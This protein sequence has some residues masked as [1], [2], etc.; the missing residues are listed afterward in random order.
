[1]ETI[2]VTYCVPV[3]ETPDR[4]SHLTG[5]E[6]HQKEEKLQK[7]KFKKKNNMITV[8]IYRCGFWCWLVILRTFFKVALKYWNKWKVS[9]CPQEALRF[10][11]GPITSKEAHQHHDSTHGYQDVN[12]CKDTDAQCVSSPAPLGGSAAP[13][14]GICPRCSWSA[15][16]GN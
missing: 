7:T 15:D 10:L 4:C 13:A 16:T 2:T 9:H 1:M 11:N 12:A 14:V 8:F 6:D 5:K 3:H